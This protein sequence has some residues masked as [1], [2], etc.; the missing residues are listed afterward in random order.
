MSR[1]LPA[2]LW[3]GVTCMGGTAEYKNSL[4]ALAESRPDSETLKIVF[5][6]VQVKFGLAQ[7]A[8]S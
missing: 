7:G 6:V 1:F 8:T 2:L 5:P 3:L 4:N